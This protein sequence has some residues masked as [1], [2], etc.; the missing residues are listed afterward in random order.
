MGF[1]DGSCG[2]PRAQAGAR[3]GRARA[4]GA[5]ASEFGDRKGARLILAPR[6]RLSLQSL[7]L[8][9]R[10]QGLDASVDLGEMMK[11]DT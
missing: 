2:V 7:I 1:C 6:E 3:S 10:S 8:I 4:M 11:R 5:V 9:V